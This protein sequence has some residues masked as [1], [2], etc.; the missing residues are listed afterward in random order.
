MLFI[1]IVD[2]FDKSVYEDNDDIY[3]KCDRVVIMIPLIVSFDLV[4]PV[5][6]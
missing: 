5:E 6:V 1:H 3:I 2:N 4:S